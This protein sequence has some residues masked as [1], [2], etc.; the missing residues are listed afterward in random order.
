MGSK[1]LAV[2]SILEMTENWAKA[3]QVPRH[4]PLRMH[5]TGGLRGLLALLIV[6]VGCGGGTV[7][8]VI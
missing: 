2:Q 6:I 1:A 8:V 3:R 5:D 7:P 4:S